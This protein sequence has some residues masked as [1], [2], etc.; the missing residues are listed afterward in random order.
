MNVRNAALF[1]ACLVLASGLAEAQEPYRFTVPGRG[2]AVELEVPSLDQ[3][4]GQSQDGRFKLVGESSSSG[5]ILSVFVEP[6]RSRTSEECR[7]EYWSQ[8]SRNPGIAKDT[9]TPIESSGMPGMSYTINATHKGQAISSQNTNTYIFHD[10]TCID[11]HLSIFPARESGPG[12]L[13]GIAATLSVRE[14]PGA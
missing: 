6:T 4:Q 5:V 13:R 12:I 10:G 14:L 9:I 11:V 2:W 7:D 1:A 3:Y 8:A